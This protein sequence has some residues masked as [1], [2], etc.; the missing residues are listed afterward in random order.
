[1]TKILITGSTDGIGRRAAVALA[2]TGHDVVVHGRSATKLADAG[3]EV[4]GAASTPVAAVQADLSTVHGTRSFI[5]DLRR[6]HADLDVVV[7]NAGV[8]RSD[9]PISD[10]GWDLRFAVNTVAPYLLTAALIDSLPDTGRIV[11][12]SSAAQAP[13]DLDGLTS[14]VALDQQL[15]YAQSKLALTM[16]SMELGR[17]RAADGPMIVAVNPGSLL[18]TRMV[19]EGYGIAGNDVNIGTDILVR[20]AVGD[21]FATAGGRYFDNDARRFGDPHPDAMDSARCSAL[22]EALDS[23]LA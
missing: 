1:M 7:N 19:H 15:T 22:L 9:T 5:A 4:E 6:D 3:A 11:N 14:G 21:D 23:L 10:D 20:S 13:V 2:A 18:A 8:F 16:F 12:L 17:R